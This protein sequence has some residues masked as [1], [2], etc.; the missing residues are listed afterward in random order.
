M[1]YVELKSAWD[2][3]Q[4]D[5]IRN[6]NV[7]QDELMAS[8]HSKS[9]SE[10]SKIKRSLQSKFFIAVLSAIATPLLA[11][12]SVLEPALNPLEFIFSPVE[13][14]AFFGLMALTIGV[15]LYFNFQAYSRINAIQDSAFNLKENLQH[16]IVAMQ[17]A[18]AFNIYSDTFIAPVIFTWAYYA[19]AFRNHSI[20]TDLRT[21]LLL[22]IPLLVGLL[23][24]RFEKY[25]QQLKFGKYL[26][27][28]SG[29]LDSL[30]EKS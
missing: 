25:L 7:K 28:L 2:L 26:N 19:W 14:A 22:I 29:Y 16:F 17:R 21:A 24:Y 5:V 30:E 23:S 18:I 11:I 4:K 27:R 20:D 6:D 13:S 8:V 15:V 12:L 3:L 1:D 10:I 9:R